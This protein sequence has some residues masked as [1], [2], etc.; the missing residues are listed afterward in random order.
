MEEFNDIGQQLR[1]Y[2]LD[3]GLRAE[4]VAVRLGVS[5]ATLYR[6]EKG[7]VVKLEIVKRL[8]EL[9]G[10]STISLLGI[11]IEYYRN[12][13]GFFKRI[14]LI[15]Q[16]ADKIVTLCWPTCFLT[17][18]E[19]FDKAVFVVHRE[20]IEF[21]RDDD[22]ARSAA[23][24][25]TN[26]LIARKR[27]YASRRPG[28]IAIIPELAIERLVE[29]GI[30]GDIAK[31][32]KT[33]TMCRAA[34]REEAEHI[35]KLMEAEPMGIQVALLSRYQP[36]TRFEIF[37]CGKNSTIA[38]NPFLPDAHPSTQNGVAMVT[39]ASEAI[40]AHQRV[41]ETCWQQSLHGPIAAARVREIAG[42]AIG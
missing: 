32:E 35:A 34:A 10:I 26:L 24:Q 16:N 1:A 23:A 14:R 7:E 39:T 20:L 4:E 30:G 18:S 42:Q 36:N 9:L 5:R 38:I 40:A 29:V 27:V 19:A 8:A 33:A 12:P 21:G 28:I 37:Y 13:V 31:D 17:S 2:R 41:A 25:V 6:Y 3:S 11:G 22:G 15:E